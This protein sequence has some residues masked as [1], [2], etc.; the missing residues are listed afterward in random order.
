MRIKAKKRQLNQM[1]GTPIFNTD[2]CYSIAFISQ[3]IIYTSF[4]FVFSGCIA[5]SDQ[6]KLQQLT[7]LPRNICKIAVVPFLNE[8]EMSRGDVIFYRVFVAELNKSQDYVVVQEGDV[9]KIYRQ[10]RISPKENASL[11][12]MIIIADRLG[13]D[14]LIRGTIV[15]MKEDE[16]RMNTEPELAVDLQLIDASTGKTILTTYHARTGEEYRKVMHF[17]LVNTITELCGR[18]AQEVLEIWKEK[19]LSKCPD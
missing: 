18:V 11:E 17:G 2:A 15:L 7:Q 9:R 12:Q 5:S 13:V 19:G 4:L 14:A 1:I 10:M 6:P 16:G 8:S 3:F